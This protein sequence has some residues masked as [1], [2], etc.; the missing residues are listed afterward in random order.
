M[1]SVNRFAAESICHQKFRSV[2]FV[3]FVFISTISVFST[4]FI[5]ANISS[6]IA[7]SKKRLGADI[8]VVPAGFDQNAKDALFEGTACTI[9]FDDPPVEELLAAEGVRSVSPELYLATLPLSCCS[10]G[11]VQIIAIDPETDFSIGAWLDENNVRQIGLHEV[12]AGS[13]TGLKKGS[14]LQMYGEDFHVS[15]VLDETGMGYDKSVF[16]S[17]QA[18]DSI[19]S[20]EKYDHLFGGRSGL[21]SMIMVDTDGSSSP[22]NVA[23]TISSGL[24]HSNVSAYTVGGLISGLSEKLDMFTLF[25]D[26]LNAFVLV[27][28][29]FALFTLVTVNMQQ[30]RNR[31][32]SLLSAGIEKQRIIRIFFTEYLC[33]LIAGFVLG[34]V[35]VCLLIFPLYPAIRQ[36]LELPYKFTG[37]QGLALLFL[38]TLLTDLL[39][40]GISVGASFFSILTRQPAELAEEQV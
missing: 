9:L 20:S 11:G 19:T 30:R 10:T 36:T 5:A 17:Y 15:D 7:Q 28:S 21:V 25:G 31:V 26:I 27:V 29:A 39:L 13:G 8:I 12:I 40:L 37:V 23:K 38:K 2:I 18:A 33:L 3:I 35:T 34:T 14:D 1:L 16:I 32:G 22:E 24:G 6:G 4:N